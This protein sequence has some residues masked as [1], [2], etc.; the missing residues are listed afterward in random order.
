MEKILYSEIA[1]ICAVVLVAGVI[2]TIILLTRDR[3]EMIYNN[4]V[5]YNDHDKMRVVSIPTGYQ[6][7]SNSNPTYYSNGTVKIK[8]ST[9][10]KFGVF[11]FVDGRIVIPD[12]YNTEN[13]VPTQL[14]INGKTTN[15]Y[16]FKTTSKAGENNNRMV[17]YTDEGDRLNVTEYNENTDTLYGFIKTKYLNLSEKRKG[18]KVSTKN[19]YSTQKIEIKNAEYLETFETEDETY[20]LWKIIGDDNT[21]YINLYEA[22]DEERDLVQTINNPLG[23]SME[24]TNTQVYFLKDGTPRIMTSKTYD[25]DDNEKFE[26]KFYNTKFNDKGDG[27]ISLDENL[28]T[29]FQVGN[30]VYYQF[31]YG[32]TEEDYDFSEN[33][34]FVSQY[35]SIDTYELNLKNGKYKKVNFDYIVTGGEISTNHTEINSIR[36]NTILLSAKKIDDEKLLPES[37]IL[38]NDDLDTK[39]IEYNINSITK[40]TDDRYLVYADD[41]QYLIDEDY[42]KVCFLGNYDNIFTTEESVILSDSTY[43]YVCTLDGLL[44]KKYNK[45]EITNAH[46]EKYYIVNTAKT[47]DDVLY[48][49]K[50]LERLGVRSSQIV[51]VSENTNTHIF[52]GKNYVNYDD[53][54]LKNN[55]WITTRVRENGGKYSY[56]FY[57]LRGK[58]LLTLD[59]F[60]TPDRTLTYW[61]YTDDD[62]MIIHIATN[63]AGVEYYIVLD[64]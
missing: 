24:I 8:N 27:I 43:S 48:S 64:R 14:K 4:E 60:N 38:I 37:N 26:Y 59:N 44:V 17:Y 21:E 22:D 9:S 52:N 54:I 13:I 56:D 58:L 10:S 35:F 39:E 31:L 16:I 11:S 19:K 46:D 23:Q 45:G 7:L 33:V 62:H 5:E 20:E 63:V 40:I 34:D 12:E 2:T 55:A 28:L 51:S 32:A 41:G 49:E 18:V 61:G 47:V 36:K 29:S 25:H 57:N 6:L 1:I 50:Y 53:K 42:E 30:S 3:F 15:D